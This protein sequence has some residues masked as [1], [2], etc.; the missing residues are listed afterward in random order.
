MLR[1]AIQ[2]KYSMDEAAAALGMS[3]QNLYYRTTGE[4]DPEFVK[5]VKEALPKVVI[6]DIMTQLNS[7]NEEQVGYP[8]GH[9]AMRVIITLSESNAVAIKTNERLAKMLE[10]ERL[11]SGAGQQKGSIPDQA[12]AGLVKIL[13][14][15]AV[16][17]K[18]WRSEEEFLAYAMNKMYVAPAAPQ[19]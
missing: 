9:D 11:N 6:T 1:E 19:K 5:A 16:G 10:E 2:V 14:T 13:A 15:V 12:L 4:V 3:R 7:V 18:K 17:S 8:G